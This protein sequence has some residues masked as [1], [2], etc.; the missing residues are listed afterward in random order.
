MNRNVKQFVNQ[1]KSG[2]FT[3]A[4]LDSMLNKIQGLV[5]LT[6]KEYI[7][8]VGMMNDFGKPSK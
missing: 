2:K 3:K 4:Q 6:D 7:Y 1:A 5:Y 8:C